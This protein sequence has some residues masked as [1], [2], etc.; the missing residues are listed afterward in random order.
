MLISNKTNK[1]FNI[2]SSEIH[3]FISLS[4]I[5]NS[6]ILVNESYLYNS[7]LKYKK[8]YKLYTIIRINNTKKLTLE[9]VKKKL[10]N[11]CYNFLNVF[12]RSKIDELSFYREYDHKLKFIDEINKIKLS[13]SR[14]YLISNSK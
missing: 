11:E 2:I 13:R 14:I 8:C 5:R 3:N 10:L 4:I 6:R 9:N 1:L 7:K 12:D